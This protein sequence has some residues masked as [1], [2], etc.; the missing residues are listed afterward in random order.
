M[1]RR[2]QLVRV[3][4]GS[5]EGA[6]GVVDDI[7]VDRDG[8]PFFVVSLSDGGRGA[9]MWGD[10]ERVPTVAG[11]ADNLQAFYRMAA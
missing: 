1:T 5:Y 8:S 11:G 2:G 3:A 4:R 10:I 7:Q 9:F 6:I